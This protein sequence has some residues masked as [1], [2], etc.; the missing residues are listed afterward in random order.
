MGSAYRTMLEEGVRFAAGT[1]SGAIP[2]VFHHQFLDGLLVFG[3]CS[4][5]GP[6]ELLRSATS[7]AAAACRLDTVAGT[8]CEGLAADLL[9]VRGNPLE[10]LHPVSS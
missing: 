6:A 8:L 2:N 4:G 7:E 3:R 10:S 5:M 9:V 1:D